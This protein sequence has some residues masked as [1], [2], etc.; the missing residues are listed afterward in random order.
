MN[1][2]ASTSAVLPR[3]DF[4]KLSTAVLGG[5]AFKGLPAMAGPFT[6]ADFERLVPADKKLSAD[7]VKSLFDRG[8]RAAYRDREL[9][10]IGMPVGGIGCG[11]VYLGGDGRLWHWDIFNR[12]IG[13]GAEHYANP[14]KPKSPFEQGFALK[15]GSGGQSQI[16][17][18]DRSGWRDLT[19][20]GEYPLAFVEYRDPA[21]PVSLTLEAGSPFVPLEVEDS[22]Y[23]ATA[24]HFAVKNTGVERVEI[25]LAGWLENAVCLH[26]GQAREIQRRNRVVHRA[27]FI[28]LE[29]SAE[30]I[31][32]AHV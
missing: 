3:R 22:S 14:M 4:L 32:R 2:P 21:V 18:L 11:Q 8:A 23:P 26:S 30:Q 20:H 31:G 27:G 17:A 15:I 1:D 29:C 9:D 10:R 7:W 19:F 12:H 24:M 25:E 6:R 13:T 5:L 16:R 28:G